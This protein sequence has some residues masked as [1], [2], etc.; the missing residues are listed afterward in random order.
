MYS[1]SCLVA[2]NRNPVQFPF[3]KMLNFSVPW[4]CNLGF[5]ITELNPELYL[6]SYTHCLPSWSLHPDPLM[7]EAQ[8]QPQ[9]KPYNYNSNESL[10][11]LSQPLQRKLVRIAVAAE[12]VQHGGVSIVQLSALR[13][14]VLLVVKQ[15]ILRCRWSPPSRS[16]PNGGGAPR[17]LGALLF[18]VADGLLGPPLALAP[19]LLRATRL[20]VLDVIFKVR[21]GSWGC[22]GVGPPCTS[23]RAVLCNLVEASPELFRHPVLGDKR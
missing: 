10:G 18:V 3:R 22:G 16:P 1:A 12:E 4:L 2:I 11:P 21:H 19:G 8:A 9:E 15:G 13:I 20:L 23:Q 14:E 5:Y 6:D 7:A 17:A